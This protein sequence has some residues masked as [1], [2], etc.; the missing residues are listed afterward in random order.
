M[1]EQKKRN[2]S[3]DVIRCI[4]LFLVIALHFFLH[5][6]YSVQKFTG[7][8]MFLVA[9]IRG[10]S[11]CGVPLF[12]ML[13]GYLMSGKKLSGKYYKGIVKTYCI[14][15]LA[16]VAYLVYEWIVKGTPFRFKRLVFGVL[17]FS[18]L[19]Y[20]WYVE[21]YIG[22]FML[23][24]FLNI[25]YHNLEGKKQKQWLLI[26]FMCMAAVPYVLNIHNFEVEGW[27]LQ[28]T[29]STEYQ[30][31]FPASWISLG[32]VCYYFWGC[33]LKEY[34]LKI[35]KK[36]NVILLGVSAVVFGGYDYFRN[37]GYYHNPGQWQ[38]NDSLLAVI[39]SVLLFNLLAN[40]HFEK[41]PKTAHS[42]L[43][44]TSNLCYGAYLVSVIFDEMV[45]NAVT[46]IYGET[47]LFPRLKLY[48]LLVPLIYVCSLVTSLGLNTIY[49]FACWIVNYVRTNILKSLSE[50]Y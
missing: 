2:V 30:Q 15:V 49:G 4:A 17:D 45:Y 11:V 18:T 22:L 42:L 34:P 13:S 14:Y 3:M 27:W 43:K 29:K 31:I 44:H 9:I 38:D 21:M 20:C 10:V 32:A 40:I 26:T 19:E 16:N 8:I 7:V 39:V 24:P 25:I 41:L 46:E 12:L 5:N 50:K 47:G 1:G 35:S 6:G 48:C 37:Y 36:V 28:P 23:I 33:Y